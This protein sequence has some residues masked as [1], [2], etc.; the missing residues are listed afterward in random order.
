MSDKLKNLSPNRRRV[1]KFMAIVGTSATYL[2]NYPLTEA[3]A[4][5]KQKGYGQDVD[6]N[7]PVVT[8]DKRLTPNQIKS[9]DVIGDLIIPTDDQSPSASHLKITDFVDEWVSAPYPEQEQD[10]ETITNGLA[11]L[12]AL[13]NKQDARYFHDLEADAQSTIFNSLANS[14]QDD[15][16][17]AEDDTFFERIV[18]L[19]VGGYY[20]TDE[21]MEDIGYAGNVPIESFDGPPQEIRDMIGV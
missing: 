21:G 3:N 14:V 15:A 9:L 4:Q 18:Y 8:W 19:Y 5:T 13:A 1:L 12:H 6:V 2:N 17:S 7:N 11:R 10:M 20:T 16:A